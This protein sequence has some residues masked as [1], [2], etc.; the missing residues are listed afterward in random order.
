MDTQDYN[1]EAE[2]DDYNELFKGK[3][4]IFIIMLSCS[5]RGCRCRKNLSNEQVKKYLLMIKRYV[6]G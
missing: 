6:R 4:S 3:L 1:K 2:E 5:G